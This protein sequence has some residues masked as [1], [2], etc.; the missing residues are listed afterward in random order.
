MGDKNYEG[1]GPVI[2][3]GVWRTRTNGE[4]REL[5]RIHDVTADIKKRVAR[6]GYVIRMH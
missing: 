5:Y 1:D 6:I 3:K 4:L 2:E